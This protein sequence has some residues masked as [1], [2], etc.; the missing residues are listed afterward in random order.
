VYNGDGVFQYSVRLNSNPVS[1]SIVASTARFYVA[2][3][4]SVQTYQGDRESF[5]L[6]LPAH[7]G[8]PNKLAIMQP[9][10]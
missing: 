8:S 6:D 5:K 2:T 4:D 10:T 7:C 3:K 1:M 9:S